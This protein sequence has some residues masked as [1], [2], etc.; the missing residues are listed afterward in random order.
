M[1]LDEAREAARHWRGQVT[2]PLNLRE[3][4]VWQIETDGGPAALRL[5]RPGYQSA[6]A[7][8]SEL[9][10]CTELA[11]A[12]LP[13]ASP[14]V[15]S[16]GVLIQLST[17]RM[18]SVVS[19]VNG[20][21]LGAA[22]VPLPGAVAEQAALHHALGR[23]LAEVHRATAR[24]TL[25]GWFTRPKWD[26]EG[27]VGDAPFWGRF[28]DHPQLSPPDEAILRAARSWLDAFLRARPDAPLSLVHADVL[29]ENVFVNAGAIS[30]IDF[31]DSGFGYPAYDLGTVLSQNLYEPGY[32]QIRAALIEGYGMANPREVDA[33][34]LARTLASVGW[35]APR[36][37]PESPVHASHIR[38]AVMMAQRLI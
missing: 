15:G 31:D 22:G 12:G 11:R 29:R 28:W 24:L 38:R 32:D 2:R 23:L 9:W 16:E 20:V 1:S 17:G 21:A 5:H 33:F 36:L 10:W 18:A 4:E 8:R 3:N 6:A 7:I 30:L 35:A 34:T 37:P 19:W 27:F 14:L 26:R 25:P 13:V